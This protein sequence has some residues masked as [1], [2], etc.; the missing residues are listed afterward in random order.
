L[1][2]DWDFAQTLYLVSPISQNGSIIPSYASAPSGIEVTLMVTPNAGYL[3]IDGT[4]EAHKTNDAT[5]LVTITDG[6]FT[7]SDYDVTVTAQFEALPQTLTVAIVDNGS[8]LASP[9]TDIV[10]ATE[11]TLTVTPSVGYQ[12]KEG[13]LKVYKTDDQS[14]GAP[15]IGNKFLMPAY[16]ATVTAEFEVVKYNLTYTAGANGS[17]TGETSQ[18]V[19]HGSAGTEVTA[20]ADINYHFVKWS[21]GVTANPRTDV[22]VTADV[23]VEAEFAINTYSLTYTAGANGSLEGEASQTANHGTD[24]AAI[25]AVANTGY[26]FVK[27]SDGSTANP[28]NDVNVTADV[29][30]EAE[31]AINTYSLTYTAGANG[32]L[33]GEASQTA[34]HGTDG[35]A[36][37]AV[38][39]TGYHFVK[40]SDG[41]T[42]NPRNDVN[43]IA[44]VTVEAEFAIN[45][46]TL[47]YTAGANGSLEGE[48]IQTVNHGSEGA[49]ITAV[50]T[51]GYHFV[52][53][54]DGIT[55]NPRTDV[56]VMGDVTV[57]AEFEFTTGVNDTSIKELSLYPNPAKEQVYIKGLSKSMWVEVYNLTGE[58]I[59]A[60][61]LH[62]DQPLKLSGLNNGVYLVRVEEQTFKLVVNK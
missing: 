15:I 41:S 13:S 18:T 56:N 29:T 1:W 33:E 50:A 12:L 46:Y 43:V 6:K 34:N 62:A 32:S 52:Q 23:T 42:A 49:A 38:A 58:K 61:L 55:D 54:S 19:N 26:H 16:D 21:D 35:A 14:I 4:L 59:I 37:T 20:A 44:D 3:L 36:I 30:V 39:N 57:V 47:T 7:M 2:Y 10:T 9:S 28:R 53:W 25:T 48:T 60:Q 40:W 45:T 22:N 27:W 17:L 24:G 51:A 11:I 5:T 8:I 31:F